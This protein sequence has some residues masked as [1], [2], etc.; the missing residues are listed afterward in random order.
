MKNIEFK[1]GL[2]EEY[3]GAIYSDGNIDL[4]GCTFIDFQ[5]HEHGGAIYSIGDVTLVDSRFENWSL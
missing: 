4:Y 2:V 5:S 3:G 1:H